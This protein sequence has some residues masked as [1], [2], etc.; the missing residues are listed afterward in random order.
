M[1]YDIA[2][3]YCLIEED[4]IGQYQAP[5]GVQGDAQ[6]QRVARSEADPSLGDSA[7]LDLSEAAGGWRV[8]MRV[9]SRVNT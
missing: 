7:V 5:P 6:L 3:Q 1:L 2:F 8:G 9:L 4:Y